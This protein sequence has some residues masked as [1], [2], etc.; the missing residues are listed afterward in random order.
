MAN[1]RQFKFKL[2]EVASFSELSKRCFSIKEKLLGFS[3]F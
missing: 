3:T 1:L 2:D